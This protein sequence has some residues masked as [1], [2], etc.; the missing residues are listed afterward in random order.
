MNIRTFDMSS[1]H[2]ISLILA[3][4][5]NETKKVKWLEDLRNWVNH[6]NRKLQIL[7][8]T[9]KWLLSYGNK[10]GIHIGR[11]DWQTDE[12]NLIDWMYYQMEYMGGLEWQES[13]QKVDIN[14]YASSKP[15]LEPDQT[16]ELLDFL[17][18]EIRKTLSI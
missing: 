13:E 17:T 12:E 11:K 7:D 5:G 10:T 9:K 8:L 15:L 3:L 14:K 6:R 1:D 4:E 18:E 16:K 2:V